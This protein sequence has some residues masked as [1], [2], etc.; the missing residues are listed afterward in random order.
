MRPGSRGSDFSP[1]GTGGDGVRDRRGDFVRQDGQVVL[2]PFNQDAVSSKVSW[3]PQSVNMQGCRHGRN[4]H[5][6]RCPYVV[7]A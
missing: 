2:E 6:F 7:V 5:R 1:S 4:P 3:Q